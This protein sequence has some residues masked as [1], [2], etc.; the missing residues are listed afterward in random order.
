MSAHDTLNVEE[1]ID[2]IRAVLIA[3]DCVA[4]QAGELAGA[5][6][7]CGWLKLIAQE[8]LEKI[9]ASLGADGLGRGC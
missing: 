1:R 4:A 2:R 7:A 6:N 9:S 5:A 3:M 8:D